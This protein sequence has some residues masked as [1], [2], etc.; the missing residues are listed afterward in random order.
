M[1]TDI[2]NI[3]E[4][5]KLESRED[6]ANLLNNSMSFVNQSN[7]FGSYA[8]SVIST[9]EIHSPAKE[10]LILKKLPDSDKKIIFNAIL[11]VYPHRVNEPEIVDVEYLILKKEIISKEEIDQSDLPNNLIVSSYPTPKAFIS[12]SAKEKKLAGAFSDKL[13]EMGF[14]V[15]LAHEDIQPSKEWVNEIL[16]NLNKSDIFLP[17]ITKNFKLS[18]WTDQECGIAYVKNIK[19]IPVRVQLEPYG[20][21]GK[22]Q[23]LTLKDINLSGVRKACNQI[24]EIL[25][26]DEIFSK[27]LKGLYIGKFIHSNSYD[28]TRKNL[29]KIMLMSDLTN[30]EVYQILEASVTNDQIYGAHSWDDSTGPQLKSI[31][32]KYKTYMGRELLT[33][34]NVK[35]GYN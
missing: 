6:L 26:N 28:Q 33:K 25:E 35:F 30:E 23:S 24:F 2:K 17:I 3:Q 21:I 12:Y 11:H 27:K 15:F 31:V 1:D 20:F 10:C 34:F 29:G 5:L 19:V 16:D 22:Y 9:F 18:N 14:D 13:K 32:D 7:Q 4:I 8:Y